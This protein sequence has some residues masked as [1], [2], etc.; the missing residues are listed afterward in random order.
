MDGLSINQLAKSGGVNLQTVRYYERQE[1]LAPISRT[2]AGYRIFS[3]ETV[4]RIRFIKRAQELGFSLKEIKDLFSL[5]IDAHTTQAD[6]R[7]RTQAKIADV[8]QKILHLQAIHASL[9]RMAE[10]C[11]GCGPLKDCPILASL[12]KEE[13]S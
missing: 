13:L 6:I 2:E 12:D 11:S 8:K 1:L 7:K 10:D 4:R 3:S 5:R 9:L